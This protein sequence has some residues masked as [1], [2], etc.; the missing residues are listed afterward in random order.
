MP[1]KVAMGIKREIHHLDGRVEHVSI[2]PVFCGA[3]LFYFD[4]VIILHLLVAVLI[5]LKGL[6]N[7]VKFPFL[8]QSIEY[9][10]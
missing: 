2:I 10:E 3:T 5:L 9:I 4:C 1:K 7:F 6:N 8:A